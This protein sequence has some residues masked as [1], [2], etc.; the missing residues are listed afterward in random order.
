MAARVRMQTGLEDNHSRAS[1]HKGKHQHALRAQTSSSHGNDYVRS[2][3]AKRSSAGA[4]KGGVLT[5]AI[6]VHTF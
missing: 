6:K 1:G 4:V 2:A 3:L 5:Y